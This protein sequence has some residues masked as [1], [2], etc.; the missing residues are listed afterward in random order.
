MKTIFTIF[1]VFLL[2]GMLTCGS[3]N[4][5]VAADQTVKQ[6]LGDLDA[7]YQRRV[8]L[9]PN[10]VKTVQA[11]AKFEQQTFT[12]IAQA[13][14]TAGQLHVNAADLSDPAKMKAFNGAQDAL[15]SSLTKL[16]AVSENYP[17]LQATATYRDLM[18]E[19]EGTENRIQTERHKVNEAIQSYNNQVLGFPGGFISRGFGYQQREMFA[20]SAGADKAPSVDF[21]GRP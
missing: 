16:L 20:A 13:R 21:G 10:L 17:Q 18:A 1:A 14:A 8:D 12:E 5:T 3:Y 15:S 4:S 2:G 6:G 7:A 19:L 9:V 11:A